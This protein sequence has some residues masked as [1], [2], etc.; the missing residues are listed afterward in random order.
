MPYQPHFQVTLIC[1]NSFELQSDPATDKTK[2]CP[3]AANPRLKPHHPSTRTRHNPN[4][5]E[6]FRTWGTGTR[7][8]DTGR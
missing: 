8:E 1:G 4:A 7:I 3:T 5:P 2:N 6:G